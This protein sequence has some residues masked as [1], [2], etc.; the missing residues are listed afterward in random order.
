MPKLSSSGEWVT[1]SMKER[2]SL[3]LLLW[4]IIA[5]LQ[6]LQKRFSCNK[7]EF[8]FNSQLHSPVSQRWNLKR[9]D[10]LIVIINEY[11]YFAMPC[12]PSLMHAVA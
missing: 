12:M 8:Y 11:T 4:T 3:K 6:N 5:W 1:D 9:N 2:K 10:L 7:N